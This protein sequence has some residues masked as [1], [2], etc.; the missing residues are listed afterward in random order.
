MFLQMDASLA[1]KYKSA[2]QKVRVMTEAWVGSNL[3]CP[4]CGNSNIQP[5][6]HNRPVADFFCPRCSNQF[7]LKSKNGTRL[8]T[9]TDGAY[10]TM[11]ERITDL[12]NPDF[13]FMSYLKENW[14]I[15]NLF[16]VPKHFFTPE[17][18]EKRKPL[19]YTAKRAGWTGCNIRL[20][21]I[22]AK[23]KISI[24]NNGVPIL[25]NIVMQEAIIADRLVVDNISARGW[26]FDILRCVE[27]MPSAAFKL[28]EI[29]GF[30]NELAAKYPGNNNVRAKIRQQLQILRDRGIIEF[31]RPGEYRKIV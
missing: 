10:S 8:E 9:V 18:I 6:E 11:I 19:A 12:D 30:E 21:R 3:F 29:Y 24:I 2:P 4:R 23:G 27:K 20:D 22:P 25:K 14:E 13:F 5:F 15:R 1:E 26:L 28:S 31:V 16:F 7:E 17:I